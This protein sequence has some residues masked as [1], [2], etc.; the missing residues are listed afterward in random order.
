MGF[1]RPPSKPASRLINT[2]YLL[3]LICFQ[4]MLKQQMR[5]MILFFHDTLSEQG[6]PDHHTL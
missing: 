5:K 4:S 1:E 2:P 3:L 6:C